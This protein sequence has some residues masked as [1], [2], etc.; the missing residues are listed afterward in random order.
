MNGERVRTGV[1]IKVRRST[2][3]KLKQLKT[4]LN[5]GSYSDVIDYL[6]AEVMKCRARTIV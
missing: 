2:H 1:Q 3:E 4:V 5:M 6:V